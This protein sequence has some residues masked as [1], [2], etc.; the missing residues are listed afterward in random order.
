MKEERR[1]GLEK[2][3][4]RAVNHTVFK[5]TMACQV[6]I[7]LIWRINSFYFAAKQR[8][9]RQQ[10][11][12][13]IVITYES[14]WM[15]IFNVPNVLESHTKQQSTA[16]GSHTTQFTIHTHTYS[17][18][19]HFFFSGGIF[20]VITYLPGARTVPHRTKKNRNRFNKNLFR[21]LCVVVFV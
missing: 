17:N 15:T 21:R 14:N 6:D 19:Q 1:R 2:K 10:A 16:H 5:L 11:Q 9:L 12:L 8:R 18:T 7:S 4:S 3:K 20:F 13:G